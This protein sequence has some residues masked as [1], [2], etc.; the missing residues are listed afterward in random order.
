MEMWSIITEPSSRPGC[1]RARLRER[2]MNPRRRRADGKRYGLLPLRRRAGAHELVDDRVHQR[3]ER[4]ID[5]VGRDADRGPALSGLVLAFD[6]DARHRLGAAIENAHA[7]VGQ[8]EPADIALI[9]AEVLAQ[10]KIERVD[11]PVAFRRRDQPFAVDPHL[12]HR[13]RH[14]DALTERIVALLDVDVELLDVEIARHL[15]EH[16]SRQELEGGVRR[17]VGVADRLALLHHVEQP[18]DAGIVLVDLEADAIELGEH[19]RSAG[20]IRHQQLAPIAHRSG[21]HVLVGR[22]LLHDGGG[23]NAGLGRKRAF[24]HIGGVPVDARLSI[25]SSVCEAC[26]RVLSCA[27]ETP[28]SKRSANSLLSLSVGMMDTR[29][30]L[31]QRSPS[32]LSVPWIWRAPARTAAS[33]LATACSVSLWAWMP[34]RSPGMTLTTSPTIFSISCGSAPPL[35][36]QST[37]QRAP[38]STAAWAQASANC[39]LAL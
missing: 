15:A 8:L 24:A 30:A 11:G 16:A 13:Q 33:E 7:V 34:T 39:G 3:L 12:D 1:D 10:R 35:V 38:S 9:L 2:G 23:V 32:P 29:L 19:V 4:G 22:G 27:C 14:G 21:R 18:G 28:I 37:T 26:A 6:Q 25:S 5:D 31:P 36:S 20:L 17:F